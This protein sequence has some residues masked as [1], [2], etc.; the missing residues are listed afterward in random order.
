MALAHTFLLVSL[1]IPPL[2]LCVQLI[3]NVDVEYFIGSHVAKLAYL[4][5]L[6]VVLLPV[7]HLVSKM[8]PWLFLLSVW[9][10]AFCFVGI[11]WH[12]RD[13]ADLV[14]GALQSRDCG[15]FVEK[16]ELAKA[17]EEAQGLYNACSKFVSNSIEECPQYNDVYREF[18]AEFNYF[19]GLEMRFQCTGICTSSR[20][21][22]DSAGTPAPPCSLF[23][24]QWLNGG[25]VEAQFILWYA[26]ILILFSIPVFILLLD[27]FFKEYY[28]PLTK[29]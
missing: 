24:A 1:F 10:P 12:Y 7:A 19:R 27:S 9:I 26:V 8:H 25:L 4:V 11:G 15:G 22:W 23:A 3:N 16:R 14:I 2:M 13:Q 5:V 21:L 29:D 6:F 20:R 17:Y 18:P 28:T